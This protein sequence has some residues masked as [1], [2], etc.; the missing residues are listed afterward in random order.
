MSLI[1]DGIEQVR[2]FKVATGI[3][4]DGDSF[5]STCDVLVSWKSMHCDKLHQVYINGELAG[6]SQ[7]GAER[8]LCVPHKS[9]YEGGICA[10]VFAVAPGEGLVDYSDTLLGDAELGRVQLSWARVMG[11][12]LHGAADI[13]SNSGNG[14]IDPTE[15]C[16]RESL[17][18]WFNW[19][20]KPGFGL[21][22]F[23]VSDFGFDGSSAVGFGRGFFGAGDFGFDVDLVSWQ[24][25]E[26][27]DGKYKF[28]VGI[29][30]GF[31]NENGSHAET[32]E[33]VVIRKALPSGEI[34]LISYEADTGE[35]IFE[36]D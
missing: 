30:D 1:N 35:A 33:I 32:G 6:V 5:S 11:L 12:P 34:S 22:Q 21:C 4:A 9:C 18:L 14:E 36:I 10:E 27:K 3:A 13:H 29:S 24:S 26:L 28:A 8:L 25:D 20:D 2:A 7:D 17:K 19:K 15:V 31:G 16:N 23:G